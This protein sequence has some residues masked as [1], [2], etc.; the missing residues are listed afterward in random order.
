MFH[1]QCFFVVLAPPYSNIWHLNWDNEYELRV[2]C[3]ALMLKLLRFTLDFVLHFHK[4]MKQISAY[5]N[6]VKELV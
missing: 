4:I 6:C 2:N 1:L 5:P 3:K